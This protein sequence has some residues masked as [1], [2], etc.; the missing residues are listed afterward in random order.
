MRKR[1]VFSIIIAV[2]VFGGFGIWRAFLDYRLNVYDGQGGVVSSYVSP[3]G[4]YTA[5]IYIW[6]EGGATVGYSLRVG[7]TSEK[8]NMTDETVFWQYKDTSDDF[9]WTSDESFTL[10]GHRVTIPQKNT[11]Y[12]WK[13]DQSEEDYLKIE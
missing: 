4:D 10:Q 8:H 5:K 11:W 2:V 12:N 1:D 13:R 9:K 6:S 3:K 7:I